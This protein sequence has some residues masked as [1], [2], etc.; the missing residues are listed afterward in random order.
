MIH[1]VKKWRWLLLPGVMG[2]VFF[3]ISPVLA[4]NFPTPE[5][6][7]DVV[8][9]RYAPTINDWT[10]FMLGEQPSISEI[11]SVTI[12]AEV[13]AESYV[14]QLAGD[15]SILTVER[16]VI[17]RATATPS[18]AKYAFQW[19]HYQDD[20]SISSETAWDTQAGSSEVV[21]AVIDSGVD[22]DHE[23][24]A[25]NI[26]V[27]EGEVVG[28]GI[29]DDGNGYVDDV[30]GYDFVD[31]NGDPTPSP[32]GSNDDDY[33]GVDSGTTHGTHVA[34]IIGGV[35]NNSIGVA[36]VNWQVSIM[37]VQ[38]LD[39]EGAGGD[40][41]ISEGI[42]YAVDNGASIINLSLGGF[43]TT[44]ALESAVA[45][46]VSHG[47]LV[48]SALGN[49]GLSVND[50]GFYPACY[51]DV[52]G[53]TSVGYDGEASYFTN[54]GTDCA[55]IAA[56][57]ENIY[58][59]L[60]TDDP[61][62]DFTTDYGYMSGTSMATPVV[63][64]VAA[65]LKAERSDITDSQF[66]DVLTSSAVDTGLES[67][68][69]V[70]RVDAATALAGLEVLDNPPA[71]TI[72]AYNAA[73]LN[74]TY[75]DGARKA[76]RKPYFSWSEPSDP[77]GIAGYYVYF[78]TDAQADPELEGT[79]QT[80]RSFEPSSK[81][82]GDD[83]SYYLRLK[84]LD[85]ANDVTVTASTHEYIIDTEV[86]EPEGVTTS[87]V[88]DGVKV[89]WNKVKGQHVSR[90]IVR[91]KNLSAN[92]D[93]KKIGS[94]AS[95]DTAFTDS[96]VKRN[97]RYQYRVRAK[98]DLSNVATSTKNT[99]KFYPRERVV[100]G[101]GPGGA[102]QVRIYNLKN[103]S[104][105]ETWYAFDENLRTGVEVA[106]GQFDADKKDEVVVALDAGSLPLV[107]VFD[108]DGERL[109][110]F[111]AYDPG[112]SGGVRVGT[113]DFDGDG[114]DEI[115]TV[116]GEGGSP[117]VRVF[118]K[119]GSEILSF[120]ALDGVFTGGTYVT[121][122]DWNGDG[123]DEIVVGA[124][125]G[126]GPQV[127][128]YNGRTGAVLTNMNVYDESFHGGVR[129]ART[130][131]GSGNDVL[132]VTPV[133]SSSHTLMFEKNEDQL[134]AI[135]PGFS[136]FTESYTAGATVGGGDLNQ[137]KEDRLIAGTNGDTQSAVSVFTKEGEEK[138]TFF[139]FGSGTFAVRVAS[140]WVN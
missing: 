69:G 57:G 126:G 70:G 14:E 55:D 32:N 60:Y 134:V 5:Y 12:P 1:F 63:V 132:A 92:G 22:L 16:E 106:V 96:S 23:D 127:M 40:A 26:W 138:H 104:F 41:E 110:Q 139:P 37:A 77:D 75:S 30:N 65:L 47:V 36:G 71:P 99:R 61:T 133:S 21:V 73:S 46:A 117:H 52:I 128:V 125:Q 86:A 107:G 140:G 76:D 113:G 123:I 100:V 115:V 35:G 80:A 121:G 3:R 28:N 68:Y 74:K 136:V 13:S 88:S 24:I 31:G 10:A 20:V 7:E 27:N 58:S 44:S 9:V 108:G 112:F 66:Y 49:N 102:P 29:D 15:A 19:H 105:E 38:V 116:P 79:F 56:P 45:Y 91:R 111:L 72:S 95:T 103:R 89:E 6:S 11:E 119:N 82:S 78:G 131:F 109:E 51:D 59:T 17:R 87:L 4:D 101:A 34:G 85:N 48:V 50:L 67:K 93:F 130:N 64:G 39:D 135:S 137:Q 98:D 33:N 90:Y 129:V 118:E 122:L 94:V 18:D 114:L 25:D 62:N 54:Y 8:L 53:V 2:A 81:I 43:G 42:E 120:M 97:K 84:S 83:V 124:G